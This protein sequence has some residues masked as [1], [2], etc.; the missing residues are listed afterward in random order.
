MVER[1]RWLIEEQRVR[2]GGHPRAGPLLAAGG[3]SLPGR[4]GRRRSRRS[5]RST[6]PGRSRTASCGGGA[7]CRCPR[8]PRRRATTPTA[9]C[10]P[11]PTSSR[12]MSPGGRPST[13]AARGPSSTW[14]SSPTGGPGWWSSSSGAGPGR[15]GCRR[16]RCGLHVRSHPAAAARRMRTTGCSPVVPRHCTDGADQPTACVSFRMSF[17]RRFAAFTR[18]PSISQPTNRRPSFTVATAAGT[19]PEQTNRSAIRSPGSQSVLTNWTASSRGCCHSVR[20]L[21]RGLGPDQVPQ[22]AGRLGLAAGLLE[23]QDRPPERQD[24]AVR[25]D[26]PHRVLVGAGDQ[27][28][29]GQARPAEHVQELLEVEVAA[30]DAGEPARLEDAENGLGEGLAGVLILPQPGRVGDDQL[31]RPGAIRL[32]SLRKSS[33]WILKS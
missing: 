21:L 8:S 33:V 29:V 25:A 12:P 19:V 11:R 3:R 6:S 26:R 15:R 9:R 2:P 31:D 22:Q 10:W 32:P 27:P 17:T 18:S 1:L 23:Q 24:R 14:R 28:A 30:V 20:R 7:A 5:P 13:S 16:R 4:S